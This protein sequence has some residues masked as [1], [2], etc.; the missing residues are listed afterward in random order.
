MPTLVDWASMRI[1]LC[2]LCHQKIPDLKRGY[3][4]GRGD[5]FGMSRLCNACGKPLEPMIK[6]IDAAAEN[7]AT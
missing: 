1:E 5:F 2:D 3:S 6:K 7:A 4:V